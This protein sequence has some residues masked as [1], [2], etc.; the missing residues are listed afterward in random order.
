MGRDQRRQIQPA[1]PEVGPATGI[2]IDAAVDPTGRTVIVLTLHAAR[3]GVAFVFG[4][5]AQVSQV[6]ASLATMQAGILSAPP[7][8]AAIA[9]PA[10]PRLVREV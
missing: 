7:A 9:T 8:I 3:G 5:M 10:G 4:D 1:M 6:V 2:Q